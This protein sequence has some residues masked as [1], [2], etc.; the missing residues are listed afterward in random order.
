[1][2]RIGFALLALL[3]WLPAPAWA[4]P[5]LPAPSAP[6]AAAP[7]LEKAPAPPAER[8]GER[9]AAEPVA[10]PRPGPRAEP[11]PAAADQA[12]GLA[13]SGSTLTASTLRLIGALA[14]VGIL[15]A[16]GRMAARRFLAPL[17]GSPGPLASPRGAAQ[18]A[19]LAP[20]G[21]S[22]GPLASPRG[23]AQ[24]ALLA[25]LGGSP[26]PLASSSPARRS[27]PSGRFLGGR[28]PGLGRWFASAG[29][30]EEDLA[31][32]GRSRLGARESVCVVRSGQERF[33]VGVSQAGISLLA[34][35]GSLAAVPAGAAEP[36][37][38]AEPAG[39]VLPEGGELSRAP[40]R[41]ER[42]WES[43]ERSEEGELS[44]APR[45]GERTWESP[46]RSEEPAAGD[47][48]AELAHAT[49]APHES[50]EG[51]E[52]ELSRAP[53]RGERTWGSPERSEL[54]ELLARSRERLL[55]LTLSSSSPHAKRRR[56]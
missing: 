41:G 49:V 17:G 5:W 15:L 40:R 25:P 37:E 24:L 42:T 4:Q 46:E 31:V 43:P 38:A 52:G 35:L 21:G 3:P 23:A 9:P 32:V 22:P 26:G 12:V 56:A 54:A 39:A 36:A 13:P 55:R 30:V 47:F 51:E 44:R 50:P 11:R 2:T 53:R 19:L 48:A 10:A 6:V 8:E 27:V 29:A 28:V 33:L 18:L 16:V 34:R 7:A 45:R 1:M 14:V 20:L